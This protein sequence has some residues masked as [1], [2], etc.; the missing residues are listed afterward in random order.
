MSPARVFRLMAACICVKRC[1]ESFFRLV[2]TSYL[3]RFVLS[4]CVDCNKTSGKLP[5]YWEWFKLRLAR[6][7]ATSVHDNE[8]GLP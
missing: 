2:I 6:K 3:A 8:R 4:Y 1:D 7:V 5:N